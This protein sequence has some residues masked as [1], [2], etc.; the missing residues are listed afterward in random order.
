MIKSA[1]YIGKYGDGSTSKMRADTVKEI[2]KPDIFDIVDTN[3]SLSMLG[4]E[5]SEADSLRPYR[6]LH[7][8]Y[9][10]QRT[11]DYGCK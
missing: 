7:H 10:A 1:L 5:D 4:D 8:T 2:L 11:V 3:I 6:P 9:E